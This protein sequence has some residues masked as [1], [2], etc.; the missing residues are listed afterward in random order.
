[1][2]WKKII[3]L[4][5]DMPSPHRTESGYDRVHYDAKRA[6]AHFVKHS[7]PVH[8]HPSPMGRDGW[9]IQ[10]YGGRACHSISL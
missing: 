5:S 7:Q 3:N 8:S 9:V 2:K 6:R 1:M 10:S 4:W